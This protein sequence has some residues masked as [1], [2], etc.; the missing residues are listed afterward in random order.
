MYWG[1]GTLLGTPLPQNVKCD[2]LYSVRDEGQNIARD[3]GTVGVSI[4]PN[5]D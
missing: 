5:G 2:R 1:L 3:Y 4:I